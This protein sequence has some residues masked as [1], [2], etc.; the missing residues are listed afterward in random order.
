MARPLFW[1]VMAVLLAGATGESFA[2]IV[3][4][5]NDSYLMVPGDGAILYDDIHP[6]QFNVQIPSGTFAADPDATV[7]AAQIS[8]LYQPPPPPV[9]YLSH[10]AQDFSVLPNTI[11]A[12]GVA[13]TYSDSYGNVGSTPYEVHSV[14]DVTFEVTAQTTFFL[15]GTF[16]NTVGGVENPSASIRSLTSSLGPSPILVDE[17]KPNEFFIYGLFVP[18]V[19]YRLL[20]SSS[21]VPLSGVDFT[22]WTFTLTVPEPA[23]PLELAA[24]LALGFVFRRAH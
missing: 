6:G 16:V 1:L 17:E 20:F 2:N 14:F 13:E 21:E 24:L 3:L 4:I 5:H 8:S 11:S 19:D 23:L 10:A 18:G 22:Y 9:G 12:S 7:F 15:T